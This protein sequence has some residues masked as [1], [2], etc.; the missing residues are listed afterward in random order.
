MGVRWSILHQYSSSGVSEHLCSAGQCTEMVSTCQVAL[1][2]S[3]CLGPHGP[4]P[5]RLLCP[6]DSPGRN[7]GVGCH[8]RPNHKKKSES[9]NHPDLLKTGFPRHRTSV[10]E[11]GTRQTGIL[12]Y[13]R[14]GLCHEDFIIREGHEQRAAKLTL[15]VAVSTLRQRGKELRQR[16]TKQ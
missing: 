12:G 7:T 2:M 8:L 9:D 15:L 3:Y 6:W 11:A 16:W 5:A 14:R 10:A 1:V 13:P 4:Q